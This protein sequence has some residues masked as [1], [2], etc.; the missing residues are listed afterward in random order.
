MK[1]SVNELTC[2]AHG[3]CVRECT[4][5]FKLKDDILEIQYD[6]IP[7]EH[8]EAVKSAVNACPR[9]ALTLED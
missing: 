4:D 7:S 3:E 5:V 1:V 2:E 9:Q 6:E 8:Q